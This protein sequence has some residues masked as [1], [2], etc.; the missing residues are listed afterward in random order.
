MSNVK[1]KRRKIPKPTQTKELVFVC[2]GC[3]KINRRVRSRPK[4][5]KG[6]LLSNGILES[7]QLERHFCHHKFCSDYYYQCGHGLSTSR[8]DLYPH[9]IEWQNCRSTRDFKPSYTSHQ[10]GLTSNTSITD[11]NSR[12]DNQVMYDDVSVGQ[13]SQSLVESTLKRDFT[14]YQVD[15]FDQD[16][17]DDFLLENDNFSIDDE[18]SADFIEP[19]DVVIDDDQP[20]ENAIFDEPQALPGLTISTPSPDHRFLSDRLKTEI[21]LFSIFRKHKIALCVHKEIYDWAYQASLRSAW[22]DGCNPYRGRAKVIQSMKEDLLPHMTNDR[23]EQKVLDWLPDLKPQQLTVRSFQ[24]ALNSLL[25]NTDLVQESNLSFPNADTPYSCVRKP[26]LTPDTPIE[27]LHH[28]SWWIDTWKNDCNCATDSQEILVPLIFYTDGITIDAHGKHTLTPLN[29]TLG[30]FNTQ[31][32]KRKDAWET[33]YFHPTNPSHVPVDNVQNLHNGIE[34]ALESLLDIWKENTTLVW[35]NLPW[36][37]KDW[38]VSMKFAIAFIIGDTEMHDKLCGRF[39][40]RTDKVKKLCRHCDCP[41]NWSHIPS[42][43]NKKKRKLFLPLDLDI[44]SRTI[45]QLQLMSHHPIRNVFHKMN[46]GTNKNNIHL[47]TPGEKLHMHQLGVAKRALNSFVDRFCGGN[48]TIDHMRMESLCSKF[49]AQLTRQSDRNFPRTK[50]SSD[51]LSSVKKEGNDYS[52]LILCL[53]LSLLCEK[54]PFLIDNKIDVIRSLELIIGMEE[55]LRYGSI[56]LGD[57]NNL[58]L[59]IAN[60]LNEV[61]TNCYKTSGMGQRI[62]KNHLYFH[63]QDYIELWGP[64]AGWDSSHCESHHKSEIKAPSKSTQCNKSTLIHQTANRQLE[65]RLT[66][67]AMADYSIAFPKLKKPIPR[68]AG[69]R[70]KITPTE[71]HWSR[72]PKL[73]IVEHAD[74]V[75]DFIRSMVLPVLIDNT[76]VKGFTE[77]NRRNEYGDYKF[78]AHPCYR[79]DVGQRNAIWY[80]WCNCQFEEGNQSVLVPC[81]ILCFLQIDGFIPNAV[82]NGYHAEDKGEY[83]VVRRFERPPTKHRYSSIVY[84]G[85]TTTQLYLL[86]VDIIEEPLSVVQDHGNHNNYFVVGNRNRWLEAFQETSESLLDD[87]ISL[88]KNLKNLSRRENKYAVKYPLPTVN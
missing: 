6:Y 63:L 83:A 72:L 28:G 7:S 9:L 49:G 20:T 55:F 48:K 3:I 47:A 51:Y 76:G 69:A 44:G 19:K 58:P 43:N 22:G 37:G 81:Q 74:C 78:R 84:E 62:I 71:T 15:S 11:Y 50:F 75:L 86:N 35:N 59:I 80:D 79:A 26:A 73:R 38:K 34:L 68:V 39:G 53:I 66:D 12:L 1:S 2:L 29:M 61:N 31:T 56:K 85:T 30:I 10:L 18:G 27:Q 60:F 45:Q 4:T 88:E 8:L 77:H 87:K 14:E 25:T 24:N 65:Y 42:K 41:I 21:N 17:D 33:L 70:F 64:P 67:R 13:L 23:Y 54:S 57:V 52:G 46:F 82:V 32:R 5:F 16:H 36:A 40:N